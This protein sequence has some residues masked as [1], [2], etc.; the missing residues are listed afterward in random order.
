MRDM[1]R[2]KRIVIKVGTNLLS[3]EHG[4]DSMFME[5]IVLQI[6]KLIE[7]G[8]Q[9]LLVSSGAVGMGAMEL[10]SKDRGD[11]I[12]K[13]QAFAS[14]GQ[15][16][17]MHNYR[18]MFSA[19]GHVVSQ[20]LL[21]RYILN[22]RKSYLNLRNAVEELLS[23][24]VIPIFNENDAISTDEIGTAFGDNDTLSALVASKTDADLLCILTDIDGLYTGN[25]KHDRTAKLMHTVEE[26]DSTVLSWAE[27]AGSAFAT[28]GMITK[29]KA[30]KIASE[31]GCASVIVNGGSPGILM[32]VVSGED[33]GTLFVP[34]VRRSQ[35]ERWILQSTP[36][37]RILVDE[38]A[39]EA[40]RH[41]KS[42][43]P[44]GIIS[45]HGVFERGTVVMI[46][47]E[48]KAVPSFDSSELASLIG[49]HTGSI[50]KIV[51][52][53]QRRDVIARPE[54]IVFIDT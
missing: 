15:P 28:G 4:I 3:S 46:N 18:L 32:K 27:G 29:L 40:L 44:S 23:M 35:R 49:A 24:D 14:V 21:T 42:L 45:I 34:K 31:A 51:G 9:P 11:T 26:I 39:M 6:H 54:D 47:D 7:K 20:V 13:R 17:L 52:D 12:V 48:A 10:G 5:N 41:H 50:R 19:Y 37:G 53:D 2:V 25:P 33:V 1:S 8:Y 38:G 16:L 36:K 30:A 43:L 22:N